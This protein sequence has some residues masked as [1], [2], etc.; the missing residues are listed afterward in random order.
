MV[1]PVECI[2]FVS[3]IWVQPELWNLD[4]ADDSWI[5]FTELCYETTKY[6]NSRRSKYKFI[7]LNSMY[8][9]WFLY[10]LL[11]LCSHLPET[12]FPLRWVIFEQYERDF[13]FQL[14]LLSKDLDYPISRNKIGRWPIPCSF[15]SLFFRRLNVQL[16]P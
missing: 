3:F 11:P 8:C 9:Y 5:W 1:H 10:F 4:F 12:S 7:Y 15:R 16:W 6:E 13:D 2:I 14:L